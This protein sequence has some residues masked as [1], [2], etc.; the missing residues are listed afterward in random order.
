MGVLCAEHDW[1][2]LIIAIHELYHL[3]ES[4]NDYCHQVARQYC[5][6]EQ[7]GVVERERK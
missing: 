3:R 4:N 7:W 2:P 6:I 1:V 5:D